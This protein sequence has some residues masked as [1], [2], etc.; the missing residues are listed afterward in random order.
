MELLINIDVD[1]MERAIVFYQT[2]LDLRPGRRLFGGSVVEMIGA[3][4]RIYLLAKPSGSSASTAAPLRR[5]Y[6]RHWTPV[7]LDFVVEDITAAVQRAS[8][9]GATLEGEIQAHEWG[10]LAVMSDPFGH[11]FCF[12]QFA[13]KGYDEVA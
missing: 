3:S 10:R 4:T 5:D 6:Q 13:G 1:D 2:G 12:L 8:A 11:G 9:A 7:H